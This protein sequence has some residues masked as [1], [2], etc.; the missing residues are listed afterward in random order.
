MEGLDIVIETGLMY[1]QGIVLTVGRR[2]SHPVLDALMVLGSLG[3]SCWCQ[4]TAGRML[5]LSDASQSFFFA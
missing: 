2:N 4:A 5:V 3:Q 1:Y